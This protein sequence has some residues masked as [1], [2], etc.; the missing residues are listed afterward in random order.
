M[1][2]LTERYLAATLRGIPEKQRPD[3]ERELRSSIADAVE[4]RVANGEDRVAAETAV[5][6]ELGNPTKLAAGMAGRPLYLI[7]PELFIAYRHILLLLLGIVVPIVG[8]VQAIVAIGGDAGIG[9]AIGAGILAALSVAIQVAFWVTLAF[10]IV[11]RVDPASWKDTDLKELNAPWTVKHLPDLPSSGAVSVGETAGEIVTLGISIGGLLYLRDWS[12]VSDA[13][14][15]P[16]P[17]FNPALWDFWFPVIIGV[18]VL[19]AAFQI[20]KLA[21]G[22]WTIGLAIVNAVLLS[23][24]A[25]PFAVLALTGELI[26]PAFAGAVGWPQLAEG[27]SLV[28]LAVAAV[29]I[30]VNGWEVVSG[31]RLARRR[32][33]TE[34]EYA[35]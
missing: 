19:Q 13:S 6:E 16:I 27:D 22:R 21:I 30:L 24:V 29:S 28:M 4:D 12:W 7:G 31:F 23:A 10:A 18:L 33:Q 34:M 17:L 8:V 15:D 11:E 5:L 25:I 35:R 3:V 26:N 9:Q 1:T 14:G 32:P 2:S 20:V